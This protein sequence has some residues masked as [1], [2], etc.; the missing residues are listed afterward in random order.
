MPLVEKSRGGIYSNAGMCVSYV[1][2]LAQGTEKREE[3]R[4]LIPLVAVLGL[5]AASCSS[6]AAELDVGEGPLTYVVMGNSL[7]FLPSGSSVIDQYGAMLAE[8][9]GVEIDTRNHTAPNQYAESLLFQLQNSDILRSDLSEADVV[10]FVVPFNEW[11]E[12]WM[13]F[14]GEGG[15][16]PADCGGDDGQDCLRAMIPVYSELVDQIFAEIMSIVDP[17]DQVI[18]VQDFYQL[19]TERRT[20]AELLYPYFE[21]LQEYTQEI[22]GRY[23][24]PIALVWDDFMGSDGEIP[25]LVAAGLVQ[26]DGLHLSEDGAQR[27]ANLYHDL[28]YQLSG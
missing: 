15:R 3:M 13:T 25:N 23:G 17:D 1:S 9:F 7:M 19:H 16:D 27:V 12:P 6:P 14:S 26:S 5:L 22:A 18:L 21:Q 2:H 24:I 28:G 10:M 8:D 11:V 20:D 4:R